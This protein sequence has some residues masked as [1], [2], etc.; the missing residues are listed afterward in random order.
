[1]PVKWFKADTLYEPKKKRMLQN[2]TELRLGKT[3][4]CTRSIKVTFNKITNGYW[5]WTIKM[6]KTIGSKLE[7]INLGK[8]SRA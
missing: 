3:N 8:T 7:S 1:M 5:Q 6:L 2:K 4:F